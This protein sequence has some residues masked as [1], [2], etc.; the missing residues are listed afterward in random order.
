[1]KVSNVTGSDSHSDICLNFENFQDVRQ[2]IIIL[3]KL[4]KNDCIVKFLGFCI[5]PNL[6]VV[7]ELAEHRCLKTAL[8]DTKH[9]ISRLLLFRIAQQVAC[10]LDF[11]HARNII[12]RDIKPGNILIFSFDEDAHV[13]AKLTDFGTADFI[14]PDGM[15]LETGTPGFVAPELYNFNDEYTSRVDIFSFGMVLY[16]MITRRAPY[17]ELTTRHMVITAVKEGERPRYRF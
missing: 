11:I 7:M 1:M 17:Y 16:Q 10:G 8:N 6:C 3:S 12:H 5:P 2:E 4:R 14:G 9:P 15:K 13:N